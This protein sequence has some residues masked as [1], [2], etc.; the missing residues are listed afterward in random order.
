ALC[1]LNSRA[2]ESCCEG[3]AGTVSRTASRRGVGNAGNVRRARV[4]NRVSAEGETTSP[5]GVGGSV[6][7]GGAVAGVVETEGATGGA[8]GAV[9]VHHVRVHECELIGGGSIGLRSVDRED[10]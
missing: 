4:Q 7:L 8:D 6:R 2:A 1:G 9:E 5:P 10:P 3:R